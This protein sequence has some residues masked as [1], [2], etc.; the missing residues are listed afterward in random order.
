MFTTVG[1]GLTIMGMDVL[2]K[3]EFLVNT[4]KRRLTLGETLN[5]TNADKGHVAAL[6]LVLNRR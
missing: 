1:P 4:M 2:E 6:N 3:Y 5:Y